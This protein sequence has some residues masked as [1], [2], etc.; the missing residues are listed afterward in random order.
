MG[1]TTSTFCTPSARAIPS[2]DELAGRLVPQGAAGARVLLLPGHGGGAVVE[3]HQHV[4]GGRRVVDHLDEAVDA[5][6]DEG[7]V[8][9][10]RHHPAGVG[11]GEGVAQ[12]E[13]D[14]ER[15]AHGH[16]GVH[17]LVG[18]Q[19]AERVAADVAGHD[20]VE[21]AERRRR[22]GGRGRPRRAAAASRAA[23]PAPASVSRARMRRTRSTF[24]SP[25]RK[26][27]SL[28]STW[29]P[30]ARS[31][32]ARQGSPSST[33]TQRAHAPG[34]GPDAA[35]AGAGGGSSSS[36]R[37]ASGAASRTWTG[38]DAGG[39]DPQGRGRRAAP[40]PGWRSRR[41]PGSRRA[42]CAAACGPAGRRPGSSP[43]PGCPGLEAR[44]GGAGRPARRRMM[45]LRVADPG[46][47]AED[48]RELPA[49]GELE[50][51]QGEVVGLLGVGGLE[52]A[53]GR[54]PRRS[55]GCP[56]RSARRPCPGR[57][58]RPPPGRP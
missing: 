26:A 38:G 8:A 49:L 18:R 22:P 16:A 25:K 19:D 13:P 28:A 45:L 23:A 39:D 46:G 42:S 52:H 55:A 27:G 56:A 5:G 11:L 32:S 6:V 14:A 40:P 41:R 1:S 24:S 48:D 31:A 43:G 21:L 2:I 9:D 20:A 47:H 12:A 53:A 15:G 34:E 54:P 44:A 17:A 33:T 37:L 4:A 7:R 57:R 58:P 29:M 50:G 30:A 35:R 51:G 3:H 10:D 36:R